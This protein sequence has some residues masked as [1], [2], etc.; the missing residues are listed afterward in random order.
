MQQSLKFTRD[1]QLMSYWR[2]LSKHLC[3]KSN[4]WF[5]T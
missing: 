4:S 2:V 3:C 5:I 1:K